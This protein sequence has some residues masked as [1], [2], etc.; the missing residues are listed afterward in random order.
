MGVL[1]VNVYFLLSLVCWSG[2]WLSEYEASLPGSHSCCGIYLL[3]LLLVGSSGVAVG[4]E[5]WCCCWLGALVLLLVG[6]S[7][8][9]VG[10]EL[11][12]CC[13][14]GALVLLLVGSSGVAAH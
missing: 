1:V 9:A 14:L 6:S 10:W 5:L 11:W 12:C 13:W 3:V 7:G 2:L 8:V 4:W